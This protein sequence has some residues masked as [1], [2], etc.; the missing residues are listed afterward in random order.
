MDEI[1]KLIDLSLED[2]RLS[3]DDYRIIFKKAEAQGISEE[4]FNLILSK[5][6]K[7]V[8]TNSNEQSHV[9]S[10]K[11]PYLLAIIAIVFTFFD[12][13]GVYS[14]SSVM[15]SSASWDYSFSGWWGGYGATV[16]LIYAI[17][18]YF[19]FKGNRFYWL[20]GLLAVA[21][22][23]YIYSAI[24]NANVSVSYEYGGYGGS[25][26]AG[27]SLLWGFWGFVVS[28]G[29]FALS[30]LLTGRAK[31]KIRFK[32]NFKTGRRILGLTAILNYIVLTLFI[33]VDQS[34]GEA[35]FGSL[36]F[37]LIFSFIA[38]FIYIFSPSIR[39]AGYIIL[40][41]GVILL[42]IVRVFFPDANML[43]MFFSFLSFPICY[44][45]LEKYLDSRDKATTSIGG[46]GVVLI[47]C[48]VSFGC[49]DQPKSNAN[50]CSLSGNYHW[51]DGYQSFELSIIG[52]AWFGQLMDNTTGNILMNGNGYVDGKN[53]IGKYGAEMGY[54]NSNC[55]VT[56]QGLTGSFT[57]EKQ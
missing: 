13:F 17:G 31:V 51:T 8:D 53:L 52:D 5:R 56:F 15:G 37:T 41:I 27:Y 39:T 30:A 6:T 22:A 1:I 55:T 14:R 36:L 34:F 40:G 9:S 4:E 43:T 47:V 7:Q 20:A 33:T 57:L 38:L 2:G 26:E 29:L 46:L 10:S 25:A 24:T 35:L 45:I 50:N 42:V 16:V 19:F 3:P 18:C 44:V 12:W 23:I 11:L 32:Q 48:A 21:D 49:S 54:Q 28:S